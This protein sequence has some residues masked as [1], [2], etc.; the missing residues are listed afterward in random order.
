MIGDAA[1][2]S[3]VFVIGIVFSPTD[4]GRRLDQRHQR[5]DVVVGFLFLQHRCDSFQPHAGIDVF[6]GQWMQVIGRI[7]FSFEL[8]KDEIPDFTFRS[9]VGMKEDFA[10]R[11]TDTIGSL[12]W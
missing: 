2:A 6:V 8:G 3:A 7:A 4:F 9:V 12:R 11:S 1:Q 10:T 5:I